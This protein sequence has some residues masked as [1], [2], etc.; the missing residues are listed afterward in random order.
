MWNQIK[1]CLI[2]ISFDRY[3]AVCMVTFYIIY[4][5]GLKFQKSLRFNVKK[6]YKFISCKDTKASTKDAN[7]GNKIDN[8]KTIFKI[9]SDKLYEHSLH[10]NV[11]GLHITIYNPDKQDIPN[12]DVEKNESST[13]KLDEGNKETHGVYAFLCCVFFNIIEY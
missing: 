12:G 2:S 1:C 3:E 5:L 13:E 11:I 7:N 10:T 4:L 8:M 6:F 9:S